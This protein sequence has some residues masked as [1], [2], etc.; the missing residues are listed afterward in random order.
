MNRILLFLVF[1][2][3][4]IYSQGQ[5]VVQVTIDG[6]TATSDCTDPFGGAPDP[7]FA[8]AVE[9]GAFTYYPEIS[10]CYTALPHTSFTQNYA[11]PILV[12]TTVEVCLRVTEN[13]A[14]L[15]P[16]LNCDIV[17]SCTETI[18]DDFVVPP[19]G[20]SANYM[21][22]IAVPGSSS[23]ETNFTIETSGFAFPD[24]DLI[25]N[26]VD[27]GTMIYGDTLGDMNQGMFSNLCATNTGEPDPISLG[28][29]FTNQNGVW[30]TFN[31]GPNPSGL[32]VIEALSDPNNIGEPIDLEIAVFT[33]DNNA[34]DGTLALIGA[35]NQT[36]TGF[37]NEIRFPCPLANTNY[38]VLVDG[39]NNADDYQ[40][41][42]GLEAWDV[43]V[44][45]G[46]DLR[47]DFLDLGTVPEGGSVSTPE[48]LSNFC[49]TDIQ[50]PFLPAFVSQHSVWLSFVAPASGHVIIEGLSV[51]DK[52][53][54]GVQLAL[55]RSF[56]NTC[57]G[58]FSYVTSQYT[59]ADLDEVMEVTCLY[60]GRRYWVLVDGDGGASRGVF[61]MIITDAGDITPV[62]NQDV[63]LCFGQTL[64][65]GNVNHAATG[66]YADTLQ[67]FQGCDSIVNTNL[68]ILDELIGTV[69]QTQ[70]AIGMDGMDG[71]ATVEAIGGTG[72]YSYAWCTG[73]TTAT[74]TTLVAGEMC[75]VTITDDNGCTE[76]VC[77]EVEFTIAIIPTFENDSLSCFGDTDGMLMVSAVNGV[78]PYQYTWQEQ[79]GTLNGNGTIDTEGG[80][81]ILNDLPAGAYD[82]SINDAFLD[83]TFTAFVIQPD[84][85]LIELVTSTDASCF[86]V[87]D[88]SITTAVTGG[89]MPYTYNWSAGQSNNETIADL[90]VGSYEL[91]V[92][93]DNACMATLTTDINEPEEFIATAS[94]VQE[95]SCFQGDDGTLLVQNNG[96]AVAWNWDNGGGNADT[97]ENLSAGTYFVT[98]TNGDGCLDTTSI[99][100]TEPNAP[101]LTSIEE[102]MPISCFESNDGQL[103][104]N[105]TGPF[106]SLSYDWSNQ[107]TTASISNLPIGNYNV[108]V[109]N[110]KGCEATANYVLDQPTEIIGETFPIDI[111][112]VDGPSAG[113]ITI[114]NVSGGTPNYTFGLEDNVLGDSPMVENLTAG[115]YQVVVRDAAGCELI[116]PTTILPPPE[117]FTTLG[118]DK[119]DAKLGD[120]I[121]LEAITNSTNAI[122]TWSHADTLL[123][124]TALV[125]PLETTIYHVS[126]L[127]TLTHCTAEDWIRVFVDQ[128]SRVYAPNIFSPNED[129]R[130]DNFFLFGGS[131]VVNIASLRIFARNGH[132]VYE[133]TNLATTDFERGWDGRVNG[134]LMNSGVF[135]YVAEIVFLDGR[136]EIV[137]GDVM[138]MR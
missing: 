124:G 138:L 19:F 77:F 46:G 121:P 109:T 130:N 38:Y 80:N 120:E 28:A 4:S 62:T 13:D 42:F 88:G 119:E 98:V 114:E 27:L 47:C 2:L 29:N 63:T 112:C 81:F 116:L 41:V 56:N 86:G 65:V 134:E 24:N 55:Y 135:V 54:L 79:G 122:F 37:D 85:L 10:G 8:V 30:F 53:P 60:P 25:C 57:S 129:G 107:E 132:M 128:N 1:V 48:P 110:E 11:C 72:N 50:D 96:N 32:F 118:P 82:I 104:T 66:M 103:T 105:T 20:S 133:Q 31:S 115:T 111:N 117:I 17:E 101:L 127:D 78:P 22:S 73:E 7:L 15:G 59:A 26:A 9:G 45:E 39:G 91:E 123:T 97:A 18:C 84:D 90:C 44:L 92:V 87:C 68:V 34:C 67:V 125:Q 113:L 43:G 93:D 102:L 94:I 6:G 58:F 12:P 136:T 137:K 83:T 23:G 70:P 74:A 100:M 21:L 52:A 16:P 95:V 40:G 64:D 35:F 14:F 61:E 131:D 36:T 33:S 5:T 49:A 99:V 75:C 51:E 106:A 89:T 108:I 71:V 69:T 126:V 3:A 76:E